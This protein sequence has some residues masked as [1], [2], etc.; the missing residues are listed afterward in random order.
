MYGHVF[1]VLFGVVLCIMVGH[2]PQVDAHEI[3]CDL[4]LSHTIHPVYYSD[5][6]DGNVLGEPRQQD[7]HVYMPG[8]AFYI[9]W[10]ATWKKC[11]DREGINLIQTSNVSL[12]SYS[13]KHIW[14]TDA[15][16]KKFNDFYDNFKRNNNDRQYSRVD[17]MVYH[18]EITPNYNKTC[19][20]GALLINGTRN[21]EKWNECLEPLVIVEAE[22]SGEKHRY[23]ETSKGDRHT[24]TEIVRTNDYSNRGDFR[25]R[26]PY[27]IINFDYPILNDPDRFPAKNLDG[28]YY[29]E[30]A[31]GIIA[32]PNDEPRD[33]RAET[34]QF[35]N[36][37][38]SNPI[39]FMDEYLCTENNCS[40][41]LQGP[42]MEDWDFTIKNGDLTSS[43][44]TPSRYGI[45][46]IYHH[47]NVYNIGRHIGEFKGI[48]HPLIVRYEP[49][50]VAHQLWPKLDDGDPLSYGNRYVIGL[51][52]AGSIGGEKDDTYGIHPLRPVKITGEYTAIGLSNVTSHLI[53]NP[54]NPKTDMAY[55]LAD[56][57]YHDTVLRYNDTIPRIWDDPAV[58]Y[59]NDTLEHYMIEK[60]GYAKVV[61]SVDL[62][63]TLI[64]NGFYN[65]TIVD[66]LLS[67]NT[68]YARFYGGDPP[69]ETESHLP[70][71]VVRV[72]WTFYP[73]GVFSNIFNVTAWEVNTTNAFIDKQTILKHVDINE[74]YENKSNFISTVDHIIYNSY[75]Q[76]FAFMELSD[77][78]PMQKRIIIDDKTP[79]MIILNRTGFLFDFNFMNPTN[80]FFYNITK[81]YN[82]HLVY[83]EKIVGNRT[84]QLNID[85][86]QQIYNPRGEFK[87][88]ENLDVVTGNFTRDFLLQTSKTDFNSQDMLYSLNYTF[89]RNESITIIDTFMEFH[90]TNNSRLV[91]INISPD[92]KI[93]GERN[94]NILF[95]DI[96]PQFGPILNITING[97]NISH[98][99][100]PYMCA[101]HTATSTVRDIKLYNEFGGI[102]ISDQGNLDIQSPIVFT[103]SEYDK[104]RMTMILVYIIMLLILIYIGYRGAKYMIEREKEK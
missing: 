11:A 97:Q 7:N 100:S 20:A 5:P 2:V 60:E 89:D 33:R 8:D 32:R 68:T 93:R 75:N 57:D 88:A 9:I 52:Y 69:A 31:I 23:V 86:L 46:D 41:M 95:I 79:S 83:F 72:L 36:R 27:D 1:C 28:T 77:L 58:V 18:V 44:Y 54:S 40:D 65:V 91:E 80:K 29:R 78:Y 90:N 66:T 10:K 16:N 30:D 96:L 6:K 63:H 13:S 56:I 53:N 84:L 71:P 51:Q 94:N 59:F 87:H 4:S 85:E 39:T 15:S 34:I 25:I 35:Q 98:V 43:H 47:A 14:E 67:A 55:G 3:E 70:L 82:D 22:I 45:A 104:E 48:A 81:L 62:N 92:N 37:I 99:C 50:F 24:V 38:T 74:S 101:V 12:S 42:K 64:D 26:I 102:A 21:I 76:T 17:Y 61:R 103:K 49:V 73:L 19:F